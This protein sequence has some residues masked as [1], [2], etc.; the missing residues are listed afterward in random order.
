MSHEPAIQPP[1]PGQADSAKGL[2]IG[3]FGC[4]GCGC[5]FTLGGVAAIV[6]A[7]AGAVN[8]SEV[9]TAIAGGSA[10]LF[11]GLLGLAVGVVLFVLAKKNSRP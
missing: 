10:S 6:L 4:G 8:S 1:P 11:L 7:A 3:A 9:G 2:K 5:L